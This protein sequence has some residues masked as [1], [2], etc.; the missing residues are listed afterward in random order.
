MVNYV[1]GE[2]LYRDFV[3]FRISFLPALL[4]AHNT[5]TKR[6]MGVQLGL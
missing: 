1:Y 2:Q 4:P 6:A 5:S 3:K